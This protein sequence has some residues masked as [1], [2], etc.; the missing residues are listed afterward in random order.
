MART[1]SSN[2]WGSDTAM[3][4]IQALLQNPHTTWAG[5]AYVVAKLGVHLGVV[6]IPS[7]ADQFRRTA[8]LIESVAV[9]WGFL[10]AGDAKPTT[11]ASDTHET[12][13]PNPS[14]PDPGPDG[15]CQHRCQ[16]NSDSHQH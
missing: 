7:H 10:L 16:Q 5:V 15:L 12:I 13:T 3:N 11:K 6:W 1:P 8:E 2:F 9:G 4:R 14:G